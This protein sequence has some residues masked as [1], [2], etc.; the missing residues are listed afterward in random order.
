[1]NIYRELFIGGE[2]RTPHSDEVC[3]VINPATEK[4]VGEIPLGDATDV[5]QA[6]IAATEAFPLWSTM[7][8]QERAS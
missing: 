7:A 8:P 5:E 1:M 6:V 2:W 4:V 3:S